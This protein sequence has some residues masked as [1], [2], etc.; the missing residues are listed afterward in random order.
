[1]V[2]EPLFRLDV[3]RGL[4]RAPDV[5]FVRLERL[6]GIDLSSPFVGAP[7]LAVEIV[8]P[9]DSAMDLQQKVETWLAHGTLAVLL[10]YPD[11][12][13]IVLWRDGAAI[14][15][16]GDEVL[17]LDPALPGFRCAI[18]DL[19][20]PSFDEPATLHDDERDPVAGETGREQSDPSSRA[21]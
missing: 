9:N 11:S 1:L 21:G 15:L 20:P 3:A 6:R 18:R 8:S 12:R 7:D 10:M 13:S 19:F 17:D 16:S 4:A 5:A 2:G 14:R